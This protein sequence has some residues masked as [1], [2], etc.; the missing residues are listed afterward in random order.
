MTITPTRTRI[1]GRLLRPLSSPS[2]PDGINHPDVGERFSISDR[3]IP[4]IVGDDGMLRS[5][6]FDGW[7]MALS[8]RPPLDGNSIEGSHGA[9]IE[10]NLTANR[11]RSSGAKR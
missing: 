10:R 1:L 6:A 8:K 9:D 3:T 7:E 4:I 11:D 5:V 2:E